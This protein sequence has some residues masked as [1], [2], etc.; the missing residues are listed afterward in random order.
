MKK[1]EKTGRTYQPENNYHLPDL[2][3]P[4]AIAAQYMGSMAFATHQST[5][6]YHYTALLLSGKPGSYLVKINQQAWEIYFRLVDSGVQGHY[7][8]TQSR[9]L[10]RVVRA[11]ESHPK[12][13][14]RDL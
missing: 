3:V 2:T 13:S 12:L 9:K 6:Q 1:S 7:R 5:I 8:T 11:D 14:D 10:D 4:E